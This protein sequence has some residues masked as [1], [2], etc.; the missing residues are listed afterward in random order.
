MRSRA[1]SAADGRLRRTV[2]AGRL[3]IVRDGPQGEQLCIP[4]G[5]ALRELLLSDVHGASHMGARR[6][7]ALLASRVWWPGMIDDVRRVCAE[8]EICQKAKDRTTAQPGLLH[9]VEVPQSR[10]DTW[11]M[12]FI[13]DLPLSDGCNCVFTCVEKLSRYTVLIPC[14]MGEGALGA[15]QVA[16][17]FFQH[18]VS[19]FGVPRSVLHD[20]DPRFTSA[21]WT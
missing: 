6:T 17:L 12:D 15:S 18:V 3:V 11:T 13:T 5:R 7:H 4:P 1:D 19:R 21:F 10:F 2:R 8:C 9:P 14:F 20:R 16:D